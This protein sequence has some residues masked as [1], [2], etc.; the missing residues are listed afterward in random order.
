MSSKCLFYFSIDWVKMPV[1]KGIHKMLRRKEKYLC[2][3]Q[4]VEVCAGDTSR[5][6]HESR[7]AVGS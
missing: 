7:R 6:A 3:S 4:L 1:L 5:I 2:F